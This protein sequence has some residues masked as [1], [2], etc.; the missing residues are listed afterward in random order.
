MIALGGAIGTGF[1][2]ASSSA[3]QMTGPSITLAYLFGGLIMYIIMRALGE[4]TV[5]YP[6]SGSYIEYAYRYIGNSAGFIAGWN[7]WILFTMA[8]MLEVTA[9]GALLDYWIHIP[10]W[11]TCLVLLSVFG[12][13]NLIGVKYFGETEFWF[14][15][16]KIA[17]IMFMIVAGTWL[18]LTNKIVHTTALH[19]IQ[20]YSDM[21]VFFMHG[22]SGFVY[23]LV[24]VCL[25]FC[26]AE[27]V[28]V[29]A[30]E[31]KNPKKII[32]TAING[33]IIRIILFYVLTMAVI[34]LMYPAKDISDK[35]NP[36]TDV[37]FKLGFT[38]SAGI[39]NLVAITAALSSLNSCI[40]V[41]A[42]MLYRLS[43]NKQAPKYFSK[44]SDTHSPKNAIFFTIL[45]AF[46]AVIMNY[47]VPQQILVYLF[48][49]ITV[50]TII[51]WYII[52]VTHMFFRKKK[53]K[54]GVTLEY[55]APFY[56]YTNIFVMLVL[57]GILI[58]MAY[59]EDMCLSVY[60]A[61]IWL[62]VLFLGYKISIRQENKLKL[63]T[64]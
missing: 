55:R 4:M 10:H 19:N 8:C 16:I 21:Q 51:G 53:A 24:I 20:Q 34:V 6:T 61:P 3:I 36:F 62:I 13:V 63:K 44:V 17:V 58:A 14:A 60:V 39:I 32:P 28:S 15:G 1:F 37:L 26:G 50:A 56:P 33:V 59:N 25:S 46:I 12:S 23:S 22:F 30:G 54:E 45:I 27:F 7:G 5:D 64:K 18:I 2:L 42:R 52:L 57:L 9:T 29:A 47:T 35:T 43:L 40:Y 11:I 31:A 49:I 48:A 41:A 38:A